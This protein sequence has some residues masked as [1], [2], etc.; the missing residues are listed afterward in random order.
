MGSALSCNSE[1]SDGE[2]EEQI[3]GSLR[4]TLSAFNRAFAHG[5]LITL[6]SL[7]SRTYLHTNGSHQAILKSG[8]FRYLEQRKTQLDSGHLEVLDYEMGEEAISFYTHTA[9]VT[10]VVKVRSR[11]LNDTLENAYRVT[12]VW[13]YDGLTW[14]RAGFHDTKITP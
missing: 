4:P 10:G 12:H 11:I 3:A 1:K 13:V 9:V 6:D 8:W 14:K 5:D 7:T 2:S